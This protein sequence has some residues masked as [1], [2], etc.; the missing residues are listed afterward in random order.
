LLKYLEAQYREHVLLDWER[1]QLSQVHDPSLDLPFTEIEIK[2]TI[3][4][5]PGEKAPRPDGFTG[6]FYKLC[7][8]I[9]K[10]DLVASIECFYHL[11]AR[12]LEHL[13]RAYIALILKTEV[14]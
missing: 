13:N 10:D 4:E 6:T 12:S 7:S 14:P 9:I 11:Y 5:L 8:H 2:N 1:L 3:Q